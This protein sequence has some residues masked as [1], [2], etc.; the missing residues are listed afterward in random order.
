VDNLG[1]SSEILV[2]PA[3]PGVTLAVRNG[4]Y[5]LRSGSQPPPGTDITPP[6]AWIEIQTPGPG[7]I[8]E[9]M[10][11]P[12]ES[13]DPWGDFM[14][15]E[16]V[17]TPTSLSPPG[18]GCL[19]NNTCGNDIIVRNQNASAEGKNGWTDLSPGQDFGP[20]Q[21]G[22][23]AVSGGHLSPTVYVLT[24]N[25]PATNYQGTGL[26]KGMVLKG[27]IDSSGSIPQW[28]AV[29]GAGKQTVTRA[30][31]LIVNPYDPNEV[32]VTDLGDPAG[33]SIKVSRD[34]G[35]HWIP[36]PLLTDIATN[37]GEFQFT[38][39]DFTAFGPGGFEDRQIFAA[40]CP[41][42][43]MVFLRDHPEIRV[44]VLYPGGVAFSRDGGHDWIPLD[45][46]HAQAAQQPIELPNSA[47]YDPQPNFLNGLTSLYVALAGRGLKRV[48]GPFATL[49]GGQVVF[50]PTC[51]AGG[52]SFA[53]DAEVRVVVGALGV[54]ERLRRGADGLFRGTVLFDSAQLTSF[55]YHFEVNGSSTRSLRLNLTRAEIASGV[56]TLTNARPP[57]LRG[58]IKRAGRTNSGATLVDF[59]LTETGEGDARDVRIESIAFV[60]LRG[61]G[62]V[63]LDPGTAAKLPLGLGNLPAGS[64]VRTQFRLDV[65][66]TIDNFA[67]RVSGTAQDAIGRSFPF[68]I[69]KSLE[70][71]V[72][73]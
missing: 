71:Q 57:R 11:L 44:A 10:T 35:D 23:I 42:T 55:D 16:S 29:P 59:E 37:H 18:N 53:G 31:N 39:G 69:S 45:V 36:L 66:D 32:Y 46:T 21:I 38:C 6:N 68:K 2:D 54:S 17:F 62:S 63:T 56:T 8:A 65:P 60:T 49:E 41:L 40:A 22:A 14:V 47:F 64:S 28:R 20:G 61:I 4:T 5:N 33:R 12:D 48:D 72:P 26:D 13:P 15:V 1:D 73:R 3:L 27:Q 30:Y 58:E 9:I 67:M 34:G 52:G 50:C 25:N 51:T 7:G 19:Q 70:R 43:Q 24:S